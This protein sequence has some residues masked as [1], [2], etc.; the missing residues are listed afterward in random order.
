MYP[1]EKRPLMRTLDGEFS[2]NVGKSPNHTIRSWD[3]KDTGPAAFGGRKVVG[4]LGSLRGL[5]GGDVTAGS[6]RRN[7]SGQAPS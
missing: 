5:A 6:R 3:A 2:P 1:D 4:R 7:Q